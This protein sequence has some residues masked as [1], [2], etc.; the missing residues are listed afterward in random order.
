MW[1]GTSEVVVKCPE[2]GEDVPIGMELTEEAFNRATLYGG[3]YTCRSCDKE[4]RWKKSDARVRLR[5]YKS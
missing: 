1:A 3:V 2:T 5:T 4:H